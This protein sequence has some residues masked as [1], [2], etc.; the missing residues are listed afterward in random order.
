M[1][2]QLIAAT[3]ITG[4]FGIQRSVLERGGDNISPIGFKIAMEVYVK[5]GVVRH[6]EV[7]ID[8]G[9]R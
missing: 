4:F 5:C 1:N 9:V 6:G 7:P 2:Q 8:F 3:I